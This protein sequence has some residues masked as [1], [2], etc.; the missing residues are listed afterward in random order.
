MSVGYHVSPSPLVLAVLNGRYAGSAALRLPELPP[1]STLSFS[2]SAT[3][4]WS[5]TR[6]SLCGHLTKSEKSQYFHMHI[7]V[8]PLISNSEYEGDGR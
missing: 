8:T 1:A 3:L 6:R 7:I 4:A 5:M 2:T